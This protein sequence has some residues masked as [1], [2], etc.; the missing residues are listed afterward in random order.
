[1]QPATEDTAETTQRPKGRP[2]LPENVR[3]NVNLTLRCRGATRAG[4]ERQARINSRSL[5]EEAEFRLAQSLSENE[6]NGRLDRIEQTLDTLVQVGNTMVDIVSVVRDDVNE[7]LKW[8]ME[9]PSSGLADALAE[10][11]AVVGHLHASTVSLPE[12][13][14]REVAKRL[15]QTF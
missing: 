15:P 5:S 4:L 12:R 6:S 14:A 11:T 3:R 2:G 13:V 1:M 10:L 7:L 8:A 9:P